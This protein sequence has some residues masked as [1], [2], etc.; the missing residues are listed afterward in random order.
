MRLGSCIAVAVAQAS[1]AA[2]IQPLAWERPC[3]AGAALKRQKKKRKKKK[4]RE[5]AVERLPFSVSR[6]AMRK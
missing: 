4:E 5:R 6:P 3:A 1:A 2:S